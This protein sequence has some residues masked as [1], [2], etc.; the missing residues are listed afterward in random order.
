MVG[1]APCVLV[2][3]AQSPILSPVVTVISTPLCLGLS[4]RSTLILSRVFKRSTA[5]P[6][7]P[8][9]PPPPYSS[10]LF[11]GSPSPAPAL[12]HRVRSMVSSLCTI[13]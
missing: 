2:L 7:S 9:L 1:P 3:G 6:I 11:G 8:L 10:H 5:S 4:G 13:E 12:H